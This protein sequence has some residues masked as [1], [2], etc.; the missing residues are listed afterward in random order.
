MTINREN[1]TAIYIGLEY[2]KVYILGDNKKILFGEK[3]LIDNTWNFIY[4]YYI[5]IFYMK[6]TEIKHI[7]STMNSVH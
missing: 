3:I 2:T 6:L 1:L 7:D 4:I 5:Y